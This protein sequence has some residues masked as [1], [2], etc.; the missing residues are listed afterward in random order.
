MQE[1]FQL[2]QTLQY[3]LLI[4]MILKLQ[5]LDLLQLAMIMECLFMEIWMVVKLPI[6]EQ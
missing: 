5:I 3:I 6:P 4:Q 1:P 2:V